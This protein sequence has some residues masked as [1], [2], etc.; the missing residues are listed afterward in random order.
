MPKDHPARKAVDDLLERENEARKRMAAVKERI[1]EVEAE[2]ASDVLRASRPGFGDGTSIIDLFREVRGSRTQRATDAVVSRAVRDVHKYYPKEWIEDW[3]TL[4]QQ[5]GGR[6]WLLKF[7]QRGHYDNANREVWLSG[8]DWLST[9]TH[10]MGH[11]MDYAVPALQRAHALFYRRRMKALGIKDTTPKVR[12]YQG[13]KEFAHDLKLRDDVASHNLYSSK[14]YDRATS[15]ELLT[16][17]LEEL[18]HK[19]RFSSL[20]PEYRH[21]ILGLLVGL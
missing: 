7:G 6:R 5:G 15:W 9:L 10:E 21:Y 14:T 11:G 13:K 18:F 12:I 8:S 4:A 17:A 20:T 2:V 16:M 1:R 19:G 3:R